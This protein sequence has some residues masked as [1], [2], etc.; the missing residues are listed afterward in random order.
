MKTVIVSQASCREI[1]DYSTV[2]AVVTGL[3]MIP[4]SL[5]REVA[6]GDAHRAGDHQM[7]ER[8]YMLN[9]HSKR[10]LREW[11]QEKRAQNAPLSHGFSYFTNELRNLPLL[12]W[13]AGIAGILTYVEITYEA[14]RQREGI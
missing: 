11:V 2:R 13:D 1:F 7:N 12:V 10:V 9:E 6:H 5:V 4:K 3:G 8:D 14:W